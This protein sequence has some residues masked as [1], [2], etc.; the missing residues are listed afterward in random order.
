[1]NE[2]QKLINEHQFVNI[3]N[4]IYVVDGVCVVIEPDSL[5]F[6]DVRQLQ[7]LFQYVTVFKTNAFLNEEKIIH[8]F[9]Y[10][11]MRLNLKRQ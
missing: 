7:D 11:G 8:I 4:Y 1:M 2:A 6:T 9:I 5:D 3:D 10:Q